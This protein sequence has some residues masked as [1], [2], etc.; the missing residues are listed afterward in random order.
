MA[1]EI[2]LKEKVA[3]ITGGTRGIGKSIVDQFLLAGANVLA[4]GTNPETIEKL[5]RENVNPSLKYLQLNLNDSENVKSFIKN[6]LTSESVDILI[7]NAGINIVADAAEISDDDFQKIQ[8]INVHGPF[9]IAQALGK[10]MIEKKWGRI[11]NISSIWGVVTRPGRLSYS[12]SK[13]ALLGINK[14]LAVEWAKYNVLVNA[15]SPGFTLTELTKTTN[16]EEELNIIKDKIPQN[17]LALP[18][19]IAKGVLFLSSNL[20]S[21][22]VGQNLIIDGGYT[23]I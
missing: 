14:T 2:N 8:E 5:N 16:T 13:M 19:E 1:V 15:V 7:N 11:V 12:V 10:K 4:T 17:R 6:T 3:L 18:E 21:Y 22:V 20:N 23:A 9:L